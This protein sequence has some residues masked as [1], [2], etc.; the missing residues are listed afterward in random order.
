VTGT[1][2]WC[3]PAMNL[4]VKAVK[5]RIRAHFA[6]H[7]NFYRNMLLG[8]LEVCT[9][10]GTSQMETCTQYC[11]GFLLL[12]FPSWSDGV[13]GRSSRLAAGG[14]QP[15]TITYPPGLARTPMM[16]CHVME[17]RVFDLLQAAS[18]IQG[19]PFNLSTSW[20][21][22]RQPLASSRVPMA[23]SLLLCGR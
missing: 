16:L 11:V 2:S 19:H 21:R 3:R 4:G 1:V 14:D 18:V 8:P 7:C 5:W 10:P 15:Q 20:R 13:L 6:F 12:N 17:T 23:R 9:G 22:S